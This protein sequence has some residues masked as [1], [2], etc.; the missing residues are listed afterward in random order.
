MAPVCKHE[1]MRTQAAPREEKRKRFRRT[2]LNDDDGDMREVGTHLC[3]ACLT[4]R[5]PNAEGN[6]A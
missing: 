3:I 2:R 1:R 6:K 4:L 5:P